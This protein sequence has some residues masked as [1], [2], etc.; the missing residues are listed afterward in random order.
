MT[1]LEFEEVCVVA[2]VVMKDSETA[3]GPEEKFL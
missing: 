2:D 3:A 1:C